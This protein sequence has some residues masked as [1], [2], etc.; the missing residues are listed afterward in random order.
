MSNSET[1]ENDN[2][3][4]ASE[5]LTRIRDTYTLSPTLKD[6]ELDD[7]IIKQFLS[8]L[9]EVALSVAMRK[10]NSKSNN[11]KNQDNLPDEVLR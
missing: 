8:T 10:I 1:M 7:L 2:G 4:S 9:A 3:K 6:S 5:D 11:N